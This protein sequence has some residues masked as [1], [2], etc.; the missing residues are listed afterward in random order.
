MRDDRKQRLADFVSWVAQQITGDEKGQAQIFLDRLFQA[1]GHKGCL[2]VGGTPEFRIRKA[3][4]SGGGTAFADYVWKPHVLIE[5]KK[6]GE[7]L[8]KHYRQAFDYWVRLVPGRPR[9]AILCNFDEFW[10]YDF[11]TQMDI[12]VDQL[13]L[14][15]L[16]ERWG[17][18]AFLFP[19]HERPVF[20]NDQEQV[21]RDAADKLAVCFNKLLVRHVPRDEAQ[22][23]VLQMLVALFAEDIDLLPRYFVARLLDD[24]QSPTDSYDLLGGLFEAMNQPEEV[25][26]GRFKGVDY[27]NGGLFRKPARVELYEDE[28]NQLRQAAKEDWSRVRPEI[29]GTLFEHSLEKEERHAYGGHFTTANDIMKIVRPTITE[30]WRE[31][32]ENART[33]A[34]LEKLRQRMLTYRVLDPACGSGNFL[35]LAYRDLKRLEVRLYERIAEKKRTERDQ[36]Q[37]GHVSASQFYGMD[38]NPFAVEIAKVTMMI[39][40]KLAIDELHT[41]EHPLPLDDLD[42]NFHACDALIIPLSDA[43]DTLPTMLF[44]ELEEDPFA[45]GHVIPTKWP[46]ADVIIGNPPYMGAKR[47]K[48]ERGADYVNAVRKT[49]R[50][51]PGMADYCVYWLRKA[52]DHLPPCTRDDP[53][54][55]RAGLVGTQNIRNNQSRVGGLDHVVRTGTIIEAVDNQ[56]WSGEANVHVS[57]VNWVKTQDAKLLP[58][59]RRLWYKIAPPKEREKTRRAT[60]VPAHKDYELA[61]RDTPQI[62][63]ALSDQTDVSQARVLVCNTCCCYTGQYPRHNGFM[64]CES[65]A[66]E[67]LK[68]DTRNREVV[69]P[70]LVGSELVAGEPI[71]RYVIDFQM[72]SIVD[73]RSYEAPFKQLQRVVLPHIQSKAEKERERTG[74]ETGQDQNWLQTWWRH[75]RPRPE[76]IG[77]IARL[78]RFVVCSRV[79]KRPIFEFLSPGIR[80]GDA[81]SCFAFEDDYSFGIL[82]SNAHWQWFTAKCSKLTERFRYTPES[83]FDTFPW[84]QGPT[85]K[86]IDAVAEAGREVRRVR[87]DALAKIKGGLRAVYRTLE[88]PGK[89]PLKDAHAALD[90]AVLDAYGFTIRTGSVSARPSGNR[91]G[92]VSARSRPLPHGRGSDPH[93]QPL[94]HGRGSDPE[95]DLLKQL[96]DLNLAVAARLDAGQPV[97]AP[98]IPPK[99]PDAEKL[100]TDDCIRPPPLP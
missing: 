48:P 71:D 24:C 68:N 4:E 16:P 82:Q 46:P 39:A 37:I 28:L 73:A 23:F 15:E 34:E 43:G 67:M 3:K 20:G 52:H 98:G 19:S 84:P 45:S 27:F 93:F 9:Y 1:L 10:I 44:A 62:N 65:D 76:L 79:T 55:G 97:T 74:R 41:F 49:Y 63:S 53:V 60:A 99:Y 69:W 64:L 85:R 94:P 26:G 18:L 7:D 96:L 17:P 21:T 81:L 88:L 86:Q 31:L 6:R 56:P 51:V 5:M 40:R 95:S 12:P 35:Y 58:K 80:P 77:K 30:P 47:L 13:P 87:A 14:T 36:R 32:I 72:M 59:Q 89:N 8:R 33:L 83:V 61:Y 100:V 66:R 92:S 78:S 54:A 90:Q 42:D 70:F 29:F 57:I 11:E 2:D 22:R 38:I 75:F 25:P 50:G 91:A